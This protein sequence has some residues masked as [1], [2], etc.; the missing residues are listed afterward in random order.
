M[1]GELTPAGLLELSDERDL[2]LTRLLAA[3][4]DA[5]QRGY[6]DGRAAACVAIAGIEEHYAE[7]SRWREWSATLRRIIAAEADPS[8]R[9]RQVMAEIAADQKFLREARAKLAEKPGALPLE[10]CAL[11]R[12]RLADP[13]DAV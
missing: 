4:R 13:G 8:A 11:R 1:T 2:W 7:I 10:S 5:Y 6:S 9:M 12:V 3:E